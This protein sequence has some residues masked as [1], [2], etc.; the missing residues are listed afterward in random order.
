MDYNLNIENKTSTTAAFRKMLQFMTDE[1]RNLLIAF[2]IMIFNAGITMVTPY[3]IGYTIDH[4]I[5]TKQYQGLMIMSGI[6][7]GIYIIWAGTEY[8][9]TMIMGSIGP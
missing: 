2:F 4:Y 5:Q 6:L 1:K 9:Q 7:L 8:L 3:I